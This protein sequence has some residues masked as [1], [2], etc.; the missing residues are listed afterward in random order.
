[1]VNNGVEP[2]VAINA[3][4]LIAQGM[5]PNQA[6]KTAAQLVMQAQNTPPT[7]GPVAAPGPGFAAGPSQADPI[8][9]IG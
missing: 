5:E 3:G 9:R 6:L 7:P 2:P 8:R 4:K 1:M